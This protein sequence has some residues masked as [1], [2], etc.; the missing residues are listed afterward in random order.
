M[1]GF[2]IGGAHLEVCVG[3]YPS[4][5]LSWGLPF[6]GG[7]GFIVVSCT[8]KVHSS[9]AFNQRPKIFKSPGTICVRS[10]S[11]LTCWDGEGSVLPSQNTYLIL[12]DC[13]Q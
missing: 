3:W 7:E 8:V 2:H 10:L 1:F 5:D 6:A 12:F 13:P 11:M 9:D 4:Q